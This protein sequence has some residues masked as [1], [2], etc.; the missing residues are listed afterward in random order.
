MVNIILYP[1]SISSIMITK[2]TVELGIKEWD[3]CHSQ[4]QWNNWLW[5]NGKTI[6]LKTKPLNWM[7]HGHHKTVR[8]IV[9]SRL[10]CLACIVPLYRTCWSMFFQSKALCCSSYCYY[11]YYPY[12]SNRFLW[13]IPQEL[14]N[15]ETLSIGLVNDT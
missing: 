15:V 3:Q 5:I 2:T 1:Y 7:L 6:H 8:E 10:Y 11:Y 4:G 13:I 14:F 9:V 12:S